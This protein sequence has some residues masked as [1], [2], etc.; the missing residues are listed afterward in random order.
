M[1]GDTHTALAGMVNADGG[2]VAL[3]KQMRE[4]FAV[5]GIVPMSD[6]SMN[7]N[8]MC[9]YWTFDFDNRDEGEFAETWYSM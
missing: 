1:L 8:I 9:L 6:S 5:T 3:F 2:C 4:W 7:K